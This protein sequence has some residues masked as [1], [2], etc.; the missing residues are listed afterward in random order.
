MVVYLTSA[1]STRQVEGG[2]Q[3]PGGLPPTEAGASTRPL[4]RIKKMQFKDSPATPATN[5]D[6]LAVLADTFRPSRLN[7]A[8]VC[9]YCETRW[10]ESPECV[11]AHAASLWAPCEDCGGFGRCDNCVNG[12]VEVTRAGFAE[13]VGRVLPCQRRGA[14]AFAVVA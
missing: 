6:T 8:K 9:L 12:V 14:A 1:P 2:K 7:F 3:G 13:L 10:C 5:G 11:T 4:E